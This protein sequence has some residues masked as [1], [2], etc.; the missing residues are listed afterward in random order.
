[1]SALGALLAMRG[2]LDA[3]ETWVAAGS[4]VRCRWRLFN[5]GR[6]LEMRGDHAAAAATYYSGE[7]LRAAS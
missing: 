7:F 1:M 4:G 2:D 5:L 6:A 3:A